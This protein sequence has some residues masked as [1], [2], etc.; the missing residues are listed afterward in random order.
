M[1][2]GA[3][4]TNTS[5]VTVSYWDGDAFT[6]VGASKRDETMP[7][8]ETMGQTGLISWS[9]EAFTDEKSA[10]KCGFT[11]YWYKLTV[12]DNLSDDVVVSALEIDLAWDAYGEGVGRSRHG[13]LL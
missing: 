2:E 13:R 12:S 1:L 6:T 9:A 4:N 8:D 7:S 5:T 3:V 10:T 11:G